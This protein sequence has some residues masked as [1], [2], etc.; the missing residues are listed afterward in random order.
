MATSNK[1]SGSSTAQKIA[2]GT[3]VAV[4]LGGLLS[5]LSGKKS[6]P[7]AKTVGGCGRCGR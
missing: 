5:A 1:D 2:V 3:G 6:A 7:K 4:L